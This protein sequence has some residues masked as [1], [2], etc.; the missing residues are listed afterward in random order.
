MKSNLK[1]ILLVLIALA[2]GLGAGY[3]LFGNDHQMVMPADNLN[4]SNEMADASGGKAEIWTCSM[5]PQIRQNEPGLCPICEMDLIP[6]ETNTS[7]DPLVL[8]MTEEAV[9]LSNIQTTLIGTATSSQGKTIRLSGK[10]QTDE[11]LASS[12]V[13]HIPGRIEKLFVTFTGEQ[14]QKGQQ[15]ATLY[16]PELITAQRE[17]LE[18]MKLQAVSPGLLEAARNKLKFWKIGAQ[19]IEAIE[20]KGTIQET[21]TLYAENSG[22]VTKRRISVGDYVKQGEPLFDLMNLSKVWVLFDAYE[23]DLSNISI[24][25]QISF[26]TPS[27][28]QKT[29]NSRITFIDPVIN[30]AT[31]VASLRTE[32]KNTNQLLKPEMFV[33]GTFQKS[34]G[35]KTQ[36]TVPKSAVLWTGTR[37]VV[38]VKVSDMDIPS[39]QF[40]DVELGESTGNGY[41]LVSGVEPGEEVVTY[42]SFSIDAAAQ[43]N[44][45]ASMMNKNVTI[46][47]EQTGAVPNYKAETPE[48]FKIQLNEVANAYILLKDALVATDAQ[49]AIPASNK[50]LTKI[51]KTDMALLKGEAHIYWMEQ[52]NTLEAHSKKISASEDVEDQRKQFGFLSNVLINAIE[53]FGT[54]GDSL[55]VQHCPMVGGNEGGDW[56]AKE[57]E[58]QN[59][60]FGDKMMRC[61]MVMKTISD[62]EEEKTPSDDPEVHNH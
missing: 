56:L 42:G 9:K 25:D 22:I 32:V 10:V 62:R 8:Q 44:N 37:S 17:L 30:P 3:F 24:G 23:E 35:K 43:L 38:Y 16:S 2:T 47:K 58:I 5:H 7:N 1:I 60:Y 21:F 13:A 29:F 33:N 59:P 27:I 54:Q 12:Q 51:N 34:T 40:R 49:A 50:L 20:Q 28:P 15:L 52:L 36:L 53:A 45:Q 6:L 19:T 11:R 48:A 26:T 55:Y 4:H 41:H 46:K 57:K 39:F 18:A 31:R 61:G 14:V